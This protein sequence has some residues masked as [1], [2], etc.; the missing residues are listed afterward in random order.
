MAIRLA[1]N[2]SKKVMGLESIFTFGKY[3]GDQLEDVIT[4]DP[5]YIEW[6]SDGNVVLF[7]A[8]A[9]L[10]ISQKKIA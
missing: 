9:S 6:L 5:G 1:R 4:D 3:K 7:D 10:L 8:K 2:T